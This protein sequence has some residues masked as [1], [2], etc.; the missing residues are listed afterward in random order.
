[1]IK[2]GKFYLNIFGNK[3]KNFIKRSQFFIYSVGFKTQ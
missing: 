1:M 2:M 3:A